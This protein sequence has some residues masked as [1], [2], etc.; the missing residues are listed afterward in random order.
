MYQLGSPCVSHDVLSLAY[1]ELLLLSLVGIVVCGC[2]QIIQI[3]VCKLIG[4]DKFLIYGLDSDLLFLDVVI[5]NT[6]GGGSFHLNIIVP[7]LSG[8]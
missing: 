7:L 8:S 2:S 4:G 5:C 1:C 6:I 3:Y